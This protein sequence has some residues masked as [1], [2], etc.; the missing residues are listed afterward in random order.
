MDPTDA[1]LATICLS[2]F[3]VAVEEVPVPN[4]GEAGNVQLPNLALKRR[5]APIQTWMQ[6]VHTGRPEGA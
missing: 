4:Q 5:V 6:W 3:V 2:A 1:G